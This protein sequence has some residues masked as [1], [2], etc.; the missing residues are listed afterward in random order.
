M[1]FD[2]LLISHLNNHW[3]ESQTASSTVNQLEDHP[4]STVMSR[5]QDQSDWCRVQ[6]DPT[7]TGEFGGVGRKAN[8]K[9]AELANQNKLFEV[10][11]ATFQHTH[12][13]DQHTHTHTHIHTH[14]HTSTAGM[15]GVRIYSR[16]GERDLALFPWSQA[17]SAV[18][19]EHSPSA[20][21]QGQTTLSANHV[22][23]IMQQ[24]GVSYQ[25]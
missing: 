20:P 13:K 12:P 7:L 10:R 18:Q 1:Q 4:L 25:F 8:K 3:P 5:Y 2:W 22:S 15:E 16:T 24:C 19:S 23:W 9:M 14:T 11:H 6:H 21:P 17:A